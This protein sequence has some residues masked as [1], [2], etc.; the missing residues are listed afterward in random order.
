MQQM[1]HQKRLRKS[2]R[3]KNRKGKKETSR[4]AQ[5]LKITKSQRQLRYASTAP[6]PPP[7]H[8]VPSLLIRRHVVTL[9]RQIVKMAKKKT[10]KNEKQKEKSNKK[11]AKPAKE[12]KVRNYAQIFWIAAAAGDK[13][14][15]QANE[16]HS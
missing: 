7:P 11:K 6:G 15:P 12:G 10:S 2:E 16:L 14:R 8:L 1:R 13:Q 3:E 5:T 9:S 4:E